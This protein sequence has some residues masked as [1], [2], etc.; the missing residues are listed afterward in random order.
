MVHKKR[1][2]KRSLA[3]IFAVCLAC[4]SA[5]CKETPKL[6]EYA[7][8]DFVFFGFWSPYEFTEKAYTLYKESGL[9]TMMFINHSVS[10]RTKDNLHYLGSNA[11]LKSLELCRKVG[12]NSILNYGDWY[13]ERAEGKTLGETPFSTYDLYEEYKDIIVGMHVADEPSLSGISTYGNDKLTAD[14][15]SVYDAAY[16]V[17]L[18]PSYA[19]IDAIGLEGYE[20]YV[21]KYAEEIVMDFEENRLMAVDFYPFRNR[22]FHPGWLTCYNDIAKVAKSIGAKKS[23][24][25]QT[26]AGN[27][28]QDTLGVEEI[29]MQLSVAMAFGAEWFGFYCYEMPRVY[30]GNTYTAMYE[31]CMLNP[32]GTPSPLY[33]A[34]QSEIARI[35][36]FSDAY[37]SYDWVKTVAVQSA[38]NNGINAAFRF[39]GESDFSGTSVG[40]VT[41][42][43]DVVVGC[44]DSSNG[45][46]FMVVNYGHPNEKQTSTVEMQFTSGKYVAVYGKTAEPQIVKLEEGKVEL[47]LTTGEGCFITVL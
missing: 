3:A 31:Y 33:Y 4:S 32:D 47:E 39:F 29:S 44:F 22:S 19:S 12:L 11:T 45:E 42:K 7:D 38:E 13:S 9:N 17:N 36:A 6:P 10:P 37:L 24:Y 2:L 30:E 27:E 20:N 16:M 15:K 5:A 28:F 26:A 40:G 18:Y 8:Q 21:R 46:A 43:G 34:V 1:V 35:S 23:Y 41:S 25:I 14:Y